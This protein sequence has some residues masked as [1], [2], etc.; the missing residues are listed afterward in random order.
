VLNWSDA[1]IAANKQAGAFSMPAK[2]K[3]GAQ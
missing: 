1:Q 2:I 3:S